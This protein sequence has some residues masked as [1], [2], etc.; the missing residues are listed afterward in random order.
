MDIALI[1]TDKTVVFALRLLQLIFAI[2]VIGTD[3]YGN[4]AL[5]SPAPT[6]RELTPLASNSRGRRFLPC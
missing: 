5:L 2:I 6:Q 3:G 1:A 4:Y